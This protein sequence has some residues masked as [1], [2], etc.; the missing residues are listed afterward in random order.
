MQLFQLLQL[1]FICA[2]S[3]ATGCQKETAISKPLGKLVYCKIIMI[4][5]CIVTKS[6]QHSKVMLLSDNESE[7]SQGTLLLSSS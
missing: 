4:L 3:I 6:T 7:N 2:A 1:M 5:F